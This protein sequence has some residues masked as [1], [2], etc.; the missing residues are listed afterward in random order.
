MSEPRRWA[1]GAYTFENGWLISGGNIFKTSV[2]Q[3]F[4]GQTFR[5]FE[6]LPRGLEGHCL[7]PLDDANGGIFL[8]GGWGGPYGPGTDPLWASRQ[9]FTYIYNGRTAKW[10]GKRSMP[11]A[12]SGKQ[13]WLLAHM[14]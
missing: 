11:T 13:F 10:D 14:S 9:R 6:P 5:Q 8:T 3:T 2:D 1:A 12:R 4:D 7:V